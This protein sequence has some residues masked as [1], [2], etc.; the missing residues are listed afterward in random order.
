LLTRIDVQPVARQMLA[1]ADR[2]ATAADAPAA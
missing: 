1:A 2:I